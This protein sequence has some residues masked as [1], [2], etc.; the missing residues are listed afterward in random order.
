MH[1]PLPAVANAPRPSAGKFRNLGHFFVQKI[2]HA[3]LNAQPPHRL[4]RLYLIDS[5]IKNVGQPYMSMFAP[6][7]LALFCS[8]YATSP[9]PSREPMLHL[10]R[11]WKGYFPPPLLAAIEQRLAQIRYEES[12][13][14][15][16][17]MMPTAMQPQ[18]AG[19]PVS[20]Q[21]Q[22][23]MGGYAGGGGGYNYPAGYPGQAAG[24]VPAVAGQGYGGRPGAS[25]NVPEDVL[26][27]LVS[28]GV[29]GAGGSARSQDKKTGGAAK[30]PGRAPII[31]TE[32]K[33]LS[34]NQFKDVLIKSLYDS[35]P[36]QCKT[37]GRRFHSQEKYSK[38]LDALFLKNRRAASRGTNCRQWYPKESGWLM[39]AGSAVAEEEDAPP[40][41]SAAPTA[42]EALRMIHSVPA[43]DD[44]KHCAITGEPF[45]TFWHPE[46]DEW[47][48]RDAVRLTRDLGIAQAGQLVLR[49]CLDA[50]GVAG[51]NL[52]APPAKRVK[53]ED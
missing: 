47:H 14:Q 5:I 51:G 1:A 10:M 26:N 31:G 6:K 16:Q 40:V 9:T 12:L 24:G 43:D 42:A 19:Q 2:E 22:G 33:D 38:H 18:Y 36:Y 32:F 39:S 13:R 45:E 52:S 48:Y 50:E 49:R 17:A 44:Q 21:H 20:M 15:G 46:E 8:T 23:A 37:T 41:V 11:T 3:I 4:P 28:S 27:S 25:P 29:L 7:I 30:A 53:T 35:I 34:G